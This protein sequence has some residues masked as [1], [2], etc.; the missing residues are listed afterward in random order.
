MWF[1]HIIFTV[2][3]AKPFRRAQL[4][5][6]DGIPEKLKATVICFKRKLRRTTKKS[7]KSSVSLLCLED[8]SDSILLHD[9][10]KSQYLRPGIDINVSSS[11]VFIPTLL[12]HSTVHV[13][14]YMRVGVSACVNGCIDSSAYENECQHSKTEKKKGSGN[15]FRATKINALVGKRIHLWGKD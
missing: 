11:D 14:I 9:I 2:L 12:V 4:L 8:Q 6:T 5:V 10:S 13:Y 15:L 3:L 1:V 7:T